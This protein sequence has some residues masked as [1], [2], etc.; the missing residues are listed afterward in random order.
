MAQQSGRP[1]PAVDDLSR[2]F[3]EAAKQHRLVIQRCSQ[4]GYF[5]HPPRPVC[6]AC[7]SQQLTF[8]PVSGKGTI[9]TFSVMY[10][11]NVAG[12]EDQIPYLNVLVELDEQPRLFM[13]T[14][15]PGSERRNIRIG[16]RVE[17][18]F[19]DVND[20]ISLPQFRLISE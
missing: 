18:Y 7:L 20:E 6:D 19:E 17:V 1:L 10:Q 15:L 3:W 16:E 4:C 12:F 2:P 14:N 13:V 11:P 9:Y 5:N 8:T